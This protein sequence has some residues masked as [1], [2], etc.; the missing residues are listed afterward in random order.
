METVYRELHPQLSL[1]GSMEEKGH[2]FVAKLNSNKDKSE[3]AYRLTKKLSDELIDFT[4]PEYL[5]EAIRWSTP[6]V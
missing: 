4:V 2:S 1:T 3:L 6:N 5:Q